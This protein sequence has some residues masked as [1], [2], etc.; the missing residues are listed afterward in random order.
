MTQLTIENKKYV[1]IPEESYQ[2]L[3]KTAALKCHPEKTFS[4]AEAKAYSK[5]LIRKWATEK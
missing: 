5:K 3:K 4:I 1:L 2:E